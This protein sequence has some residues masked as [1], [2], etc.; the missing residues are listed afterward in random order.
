MLFWSFW[1]LVVSMAG[2]GNA[3]MDPICANDINCILPDC[4]CA[5]TDPPTDFYGIPIE[6]PDLPQIVLLSFDDA[7]RED[8]F[9]NYYS[10]LFNGTFKN[11]NGC[12]ISGTFFVS[13]EY[14]DYVRVHQL[15]EWNCE[16]ASHSFSHQPPANLWAQLDYDEFRMEMSE[17]RQTFARFGQIEEDLIIGARSPFLQTSGNDYYQ[18]LLD[19][20]FVYD[21]SRPTRRFIYND[22]VPGSKW[23]LWPFTYDYDYSYNGTESFLDCQ[24]EPCPSNRTF[25]GLWQVPMVDLVDLGGI[26]CAML[27]QCD[28]RPPNFQ[29]AMALLEENF[30]RR[31]TS[32]KGPVG[33]YTHASWFEGDWTHNFDALLQFVQDILAL[34]DQDVFIIS[35]S[36]FIT[37]LKDPQLL[38]IVSSGSS[39][40]EWC[41]ATPN[42]PTCNPPQNPCRYEFSS[43]PFERFMNSCVDC[44]PNY[45]WVGNPL[46]N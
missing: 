32:N 42:L 21:C 24:I 39:Y 1:I 7:I 4:K 11:P 29:E 25:P 10:K 16:I 36:Q 15:R 12:P 2:H 20:G 34:P 27:D 30:N 46:G 14:T 28:N 41:P 17:V 38:S 45:P 31:Y 40:P 35:V 18:M 13:H 43:P 44:P 6:G 33:L 9:L 8:L 19:E 26:E 5:G 3:L 37:Y 22:T 23:G